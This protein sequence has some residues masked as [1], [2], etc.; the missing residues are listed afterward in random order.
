MMMRK[1]RM[2]RIRKTHNTER[3]DHREGKMQ[4]KGGR[5]GSRTLSRA[6]KGRGMRME[7]RRIR[8]KNTG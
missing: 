2:R 1:W 3:S 7:W 4:V 6:G 5:R 8:I